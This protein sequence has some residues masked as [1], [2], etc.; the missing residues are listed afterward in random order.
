[1][2]ALLL[3]A[4][5]AALAPFAAAGDEKYTIK[6]K[7]FP[8]VGKSVRVRDQAKTVGTTKITDAAGKALKGGKEQEASLDEYTETTLVAGDKAPKKFKR[9]Y[10]KA[11]MD[12]GK[13]AEAE[14]WEGKVVVYELKDGMYQ[15]SVEGKGALSAKD[16]AKLAE[17]ANERFKEDF[18]TVLVPDR[19]VKVG[20]SWA[21]PGKKLAELSISDIDPARSK[22]VATLVKAYKKGGKQWGTLRLRATLVLRKLEKVAFDPPATMDVDATID[23]PIDGSGVTGRLVGLARLAGKARIE[24]DCKRFT[25][26]L[27][28]RVEGRR[29]QEDER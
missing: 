29:E 15:V 12:K 23:T 22:G 17:H 4:C 26:E 24:E 28:L 6:I 1:M 3:A 20:E 9:S 27:N 16:R 21:V 19:A 25:V 2:R 8:D 18:D 11:R 13:G 5:V 10:R 7:R 14:P